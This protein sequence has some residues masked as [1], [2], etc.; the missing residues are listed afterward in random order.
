[1][2]FSTNSVFLS[3]FFFFFKKNSITLRNNRRQIREP[4][5]RAYI[6]QCYRISLNS[7]SMGWKWLCWGR[8]GSALRGIFFSLLAS[9]VHVPRLISAPSGHQEPWKSVCSRPTWCW[10]HGV[11]QKS[12]VCTWLWE[13][14]LCFRRHGWF[15][16]LIETMHHTS[17]LYA[18]VSR[19]LQFR[20][21]GYQRGLE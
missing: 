14:T 1:M 19:A 12:Q 4:T 11:Y 9:L 18:T 7:F 10:V 15:S 2:S 17:K 5:I 16:E 13:L 3:F 8:V 6:F 20:N 21:S